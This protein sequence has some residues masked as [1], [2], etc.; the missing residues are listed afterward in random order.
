[1]GIDI[2]TWE[3]DPQGIYFGG[4]SMHVTLREMAVFGLLYLNDGH[5]NGHQIVPADWVE[6][7]LEPSTFFFH[8]N[9]Y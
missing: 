4:N 1:M 3:Q 2:D 6:Q 5:L 7:S 8:P 9:H